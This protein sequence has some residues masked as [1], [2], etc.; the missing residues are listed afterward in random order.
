MRQLGCYRA[1]K[2]LVHAGPKTAAAAAYDDHFRLEDLGEPS[3]RMS[4]VPGQF[5]ELNMDALSLGECT[6][7]VGEA[8]VEDGGIPVRL[9]RVDGSGVH[10]SVGMFGYHVRRGVDV[11]ANENRLELASEAS[12]LPDHLRRLLRRYSDH[13]GDQA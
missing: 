7:P 8:A 1:A 9:I 11:C 2:E 10:R 4:D 3:E 13:N 12:G 5:T 6:D